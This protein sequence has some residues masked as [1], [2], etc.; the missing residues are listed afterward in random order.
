[1]KGVLAGKEYLDKVDEEYVISRG[2]V[3][4]RRDDS[5][6]YIQTDAKSSSSGKQRYGRIEFEDENQSDQMA[7]TTTRPKAQIGFKQTKNETATQ[8]GGVSNSDARSE[9]TESGTVDRFWLREIK[10]Y[11]YG[12]KIE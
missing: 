2:I 8:T 12:T 11:Y 5:G 9:V 6:N 1:M 4:S 10:E 7:T 3:S